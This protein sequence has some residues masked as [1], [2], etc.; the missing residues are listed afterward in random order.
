MDYIHLNITNVSL[1]GL[2]KLYDSLH[3]TEYCMFSCIVVEPTEE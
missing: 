1:T 2:T 3:P